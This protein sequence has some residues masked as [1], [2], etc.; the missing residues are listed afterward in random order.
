MTD[1]YTPKFV[2]TFPTRMAPAVF[3][4]S[5]E[6][7][8]CGHL[9]ACGCRTEVLTPL[10]PAQ[11]SFAYD[12]K[13]VSLWPSVGNWGLPCGAHYVIEAGHVE[14]ARQYTNS[15]IARNRARDRA[16][17]ARLDARFESQGFPNSQPA[18]ETAPQSVTE[19]AST[20]F[21]V[22]IRRGLR[23]LL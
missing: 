5:L 23:R 4:I 14:W 20:G 15:E 6:Y 13:D 8:T 17:L 19:G 10:S 7:N 1:Y 12:G 11:W 22:S 9:C 18:N 3:Y 21:V 16:A 2:E